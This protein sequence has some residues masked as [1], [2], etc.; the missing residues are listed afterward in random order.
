MTEA[1]VS[2]PAVPAAP[3]AGDVGIA[4]DTWAGQNW[5]WQGSGLSYINAD[6]TIA[7]GHVYIR[8][9]GRVRFEYAPPDRSLVMAGGSQVATLNRTLRKEVG[10]IPALIVNLQNLIPKLDVLC[11][12]A[13]EVDIAFTAD[14][15]I[16][17][18]D[19]AP[20]DGGQVVAQEEGAVGLIQSGLEQLIAALSK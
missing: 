15:N 3:A 14:G 17:I 20:A 2:A 10:N 11:R 5:S 9:P 13:G 12:Y 8:R 7:T 16:V 6:G 1:L 19:V 18:L 4:S